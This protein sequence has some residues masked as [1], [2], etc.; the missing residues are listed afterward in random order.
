MS[1]ELFSYF[2]FEENK[3]NAADKVKTPLVSESGKDT[4]I[5]E[6]GEV[7]ENHIEGQSYKNQNNP[8]A[9]KEGV[10]SGSELTSDT[11]IHQDSVS[12]KEDEANVETTEDQNSSATIQKSQGE[13]DEDKTVSVGESKA[14]NVEELALFEMD[15]VESKPSKADKPMFN[16]GTFIRYA[17]DTIFLTSL[18]PQEQLGSLTL[19][20]VRKKLEK[21][22]P[23]LTKQ[24]CKI[25]YD[26]KK[27]MI[28]PI[29]TLGKKGA[30]FHQ[31][32]R[33]Y[34]TTIQ[35]LVH[36]LQPLNF[37][38]AEDGIYEIKKNHIG[39]FAL[40]SLRTNDSNIPKLIELA[41]QQ[42]KKDQCTEGFKL[43]L[44]PIP[45]AVYSPLLSFFM[46][47]TRYSDVEVM[48]VFYWDLEKQRYWLDIPSQY[49]TKTSVDARYRT[50][51]ELQLIKVA[52][53]HSHNQMPTYFS[54]VDNRDEVASIL[55]GV[56]GNLE[57][58]HN[59]IYFNFKCRTGFSGRFINI[60]PSTLFEGVFPAQEIH[61]NMKPDYTKPFEYPYVSYPSEWHNRVVEGARYV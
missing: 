13:S 18:F 31:G 47:Y 3:D 58:S 8:Y 27:N 9:D 28:I 4:A 40:R 36:H 29:V 54:S 26:D 45:A 14:V 10:S 12:K 2:N 61:Q 20:D 37:L 41:K 53:V 43:L 38:A 33:G 60:Q 16:L 49:V 51:M 48:G 44:P 5:H 22:Y 52:E 46:D 57:K 15:K 34:F 24:R 30:F 11:A 23:E 17:G 50:D 19:E 42:D 35:D 21:D 25:D 1:K 39:V 59:M 56:I 7:K 32:I 6:G 55:Y